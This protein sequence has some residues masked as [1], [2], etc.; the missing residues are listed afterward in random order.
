[1]VANPLY[2]LMFVETLRQ[3]QKLG[4]AFSARHV[5]EF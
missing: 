5:E 4:L 1:M 2:L 3:A